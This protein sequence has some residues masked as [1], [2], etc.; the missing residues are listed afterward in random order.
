MENISGL[1]SI[2]IIIQ[3]LTAPPDCCIKSFWRWSKGQSPSE[4]E[5]HIHVFS[6]QPI[7][8]MHFETKQAW[9]LQGSVSYQCCIWMAVMGCEWPCPSYPKYSWYIKKFP[10]I[11]NS[12]KSLSNIYVWRLT[13]S[14]AELYV[15]TP[16]KLSHCQYRS[17]SCCTLLYFIESSTAWLYTR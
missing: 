2:T 14:R 16:T 10:R 17:L 3:N 11:A 8:D 1:N 6:C 5:F 9:A 13:K 15:R 4:T 7:L 12:R